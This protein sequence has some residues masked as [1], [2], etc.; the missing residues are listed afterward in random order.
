MDHRPVEAIW[1][2]ETCCIV[3][4]GP[5]LAGFDFTR[6]AGFR[7]IV[8]NSSVFA[9][10]QADVLFFGDDRWWDWYHAE[11]CRDFAGVIYSAS[12]INHSRIRQLFRR[13]PPPYI[14]AARNE[15]TMQ[16]TSL[17]GTLNLAVHFGCKKIVLLG[18]D[19]KA[20][21]DGRTHHHLP[22]RVPQDPGCWDKQLDE[23][24]RASLTLKDLGVEVINTSLE[25]RID[26]WPKQQ[27]DEVIYGLEHR[28]L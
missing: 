17:T 18:A 25:S 22:H 20:A 12:H 6:L 28:T 19:M 4:G 14:T 27:I 11:V 13:K 10:P 26:W 7:S 16:H 9:Y 21:A 8:I 24:Q 23:V 15:V 1:P 3:A 5:S 2:G